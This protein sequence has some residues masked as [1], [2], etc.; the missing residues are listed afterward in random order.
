MFEESQPAN[1]IQILTDLMNALEDGRRG[2]AEL[3]RHLK[4]ES[5]RQFFLR[6]AQVRAE[7]AAHLQSEVGTPHGETG[8]TNGTVAGAFSRAWVDL[9][10]QLGVGDRAVLA[11]ADR[12]EETTKQGYA[13]ALMQADLAPDLQGLLVRQQR[14]ILQSHNKIRNL[15]QAKGRRKSKIRAA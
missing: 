1:P 5:T 13:A 11:A 15:L 2:M 9:L 6:E 10:G 4:S 3:S 14:H 8:E 7:Y 12:A